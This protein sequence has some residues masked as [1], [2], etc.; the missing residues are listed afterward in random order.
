M[1]NLR[2]TENVLEPKLTMSFET[3]LLRNVDY[4]ADFLHE[5]TCRSRDYGTVC[6]YLSVQLLSQ[7]L[8]LRKAVMV[9]LGI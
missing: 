8:L 2:R 6:L 3:C 7:L 1:R 9:P 4:A 5:T